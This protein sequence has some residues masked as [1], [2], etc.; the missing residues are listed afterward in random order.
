MI[1]K[2]VLIVAALTFGAVSATQASADVP[3]S[4]AP[5]TTQTSAERLE[6]ADT[7]QQN[8]GDHGSSLGNGLPWHGSIAYE[9]DN[10]TRRMLTPILT[11]T[12]A[13]YDPCLEM[14]R[15][16]FHRYLILTEKVEK[17]AY[18]G[19]LA[20]GP[21]MYYARLQ[22]ERMYLAWECLYD[23]ALVAFD[24]LYG[25]EGMYWSG[26]TDPGPRSVRTD[27]EFDC[28]I[29][30][31]MPPYYFG[32]DKDIEGPG[33]PTQRWLNTDGGPGVPLVGG[34]DFY[35]GPVTGNFWEDRDFRGEVPTPYAG[36]GP[37]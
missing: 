34:T 24:E 13:I 2:L 14:A 26:I 22:R 36:P 20:N 11:P 1:K 32:Y 3:S 12:G 35:N 17:D 6:F 23:R 5:L 8:R 4:D 18:G 30:D 33:S 31:V 21:G 37:F 7:W 28:S 29:W 27:C 9:R 15:E 16:W 25:P 19:I 10:C